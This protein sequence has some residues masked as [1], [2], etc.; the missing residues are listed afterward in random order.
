MSVA[1][2]HGDQRVAEAGVQNSL[3]VEI[4]KSEKYLAIFLKVI[5][6][7]VWHSVTTYKCHDALK[8]GDIDTAK[9][10][11]KRGASTTFYG[12]DKL[13]LLVTKNQSASMRFM[14]DNGFC[15]E[16][17]HLFNHKRTH[18]SQMVPQITMQSALF[19]LV[20]LNRSDEVFQLIRR[21]PEIVR[22]EAFVWN[23]CVLVLSD[24]SET[25]QLR[26]SYLE[27]AKFLFSK[28]FRPALENFDS[29][30][31]FEEKEKVLCDLSQEYPY[32]RGELKEHYLLKEL[33]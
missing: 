5:T 32:V 33:F 24:S 17:F 12:I 28:N 8:E 20:M 26:K 1:V 27:T 30:R 10:W 31:W 22:E 9:R 3:R 23:R 15:L 6:I 11:L 29:A 13:N 25:I 16:Y 14:L 19:R 4:T 7:C 21:T 2:I 18:V